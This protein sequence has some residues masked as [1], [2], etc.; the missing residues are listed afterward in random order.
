M[1]NKI[2]ILILLPGFLLISGVHQLYGQGFSSSSETATIDASVVGA[3]N[4]TNLF[5]INFGL[6]SQNIDSAAPTL[7]PQ[8]SASDANIVDDGNVSVGKFVFEAASE[9]DII[10][11]FNN[12]TLTESGGGSD[13]LEFTPSVQGAQG[14]ETAPNDGARG[15][16]TAISSNDSVT[17]TGTHYTVWV[18]G[19]LGLG[20]STTAPV[21]VGAY[22]GTFTITV[23]YDI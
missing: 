7:D 15:G 22:D 13:E 3:I 5:D 23:D 6:I 18:G 4:V 2:S 20:G 17:L 12:A 9:Q 11:S 8:D 16:D 14:D 10:I 19:T 21:S 1:K